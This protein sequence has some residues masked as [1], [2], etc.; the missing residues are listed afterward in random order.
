MLMYKVLIADDEKII[1]NGLMGI[2]DWNELGFEIIGEAATGRD[3]LDKLIN[4]KPDLIMLDIRMPG[5]T[6]L[7]VMKAACENGFSGK[8]VILSGFSDFEYAQEAIEYGVRSYLTKPVDVD[9]LTE[10]LNTVREELDKAEEDR[11]KRGQYFSRAKASIFEELLTGKLELETEADKE[12]LGLSKGPFRVV[13]TEKFSL[14][15]EDKEYSLSELLR[16]SR[17]SGDIFEEIQIQGGWNTLIFKG[18]HGLDKL[19][20]ALEKFDKEYP[21]EKNSPLDTIFFACGPAV[22]DAECLQDSY[23]AAKYYM[24]NRF[25]C[26]EGQHYIS[27]DHQPYGVEIRAGE[28]MDGE[29]HEV[30][31]DMSVEAVRERLL[32]PYAELFVEAVQTFNRNRIAEGLRNL[33]EQLYIS[34]LTVS[35]TKK[36]LVDLYLKIKEK[37]IVVFNKTDIPFKADSEIIDFMINSFYLY[38]I[39]QG[40][41]EQLDMMMTSIGYSSRDSIIDD[42]VFYIEHNYAFN[43][44][45]ENLAPLFGYNSSYLGKIFSKRL[46]VN[47]NTYLDK[48]RIEHSKELLLSGKTQVYKV[49]EMVGYK[50]VDYFHIKFKKYVGISPAEYRKRSRA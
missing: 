46:G 39:I 3:A 24:E 22:E 38:E 19:S 2:V 27:L 28:I 18:R 23:E 20:S 44:T 45:L 9:A 33:Q 32:V 11:K 25:F 37:I 35:E 40:I 31:E 13:L 50:N 4:L 7:E 15:S 8:A 1:R 21:P 16:V 12:Q 36:L 14:N 17:D 48:V 42:V 5:L 49:A 41:S 10:I 30:T 29:E 43:I 47:F 26:D 34:R 6:G